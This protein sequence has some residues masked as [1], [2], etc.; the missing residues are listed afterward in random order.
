ML[1]VIVVNLKS[2]TKRVSGE[3]GSTKYS[4]VRHLHD[5]RQ[6]RPVLRNYANH[7]IA[8]LESNSYIS[9]SFF[10]FLNHT[11][12]SISKRQH[13]FKICFSWSASLWFVAEN[14]VLFF[15]SCILFQKGY[16]WHDTGEQGYFDFT[17]ICLFSQHPHSNKQYSVDYQRKYQ[18]EKKSTVAVWRPGPS[19]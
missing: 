8:K 18:P 14:V 7:K 15:F 9:L 1:Q 11:S 10:F 16:F 2:S 12:Y 4:I 6:N 5:F 3:L 17:F 19:S 13:F